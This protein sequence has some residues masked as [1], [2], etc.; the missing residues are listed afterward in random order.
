MSLA[1]PRFSAI[2]HQPYDKPPMYLSFHS[3][4][5]VAKVLYEQIGFKDTG[6]IVDNEVLYVL[7]PVEYL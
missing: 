3:D 1:V 7:E 5:Y 2:S 6:K 4:N